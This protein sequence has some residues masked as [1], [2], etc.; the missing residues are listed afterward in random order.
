MDKA[1]YRLIDANANRAREALRVVED[2]CRLVLNDIRLSEKAKTLR[3]MFCGVINQLDQTLLISARN[4]RD[5]VGT[6]ITLDSEQQRHDFKDVVMAAFKRMSEALRVI[7]ESLKCVAPELAG[8]IEKCRYLSY[9]LEKLTL[10][11]LYRFHILADHKLYVLV[12]ESFSQG[13]LIETTEATLQ[14]GAD[15][16]QLREKGW[17]D[18]QLS[19]TATQIRAHCKKH[20]ALFIMNDRAD[21]ATIAKADGVH[22]GQDDLSVQ[23]VRQIIPSSSII[24]KSAHTTKEVEGVIA[25]GVD[26][27][28]VGAIYA[29]EVKP[30]VVPVGVAFIRKVRDMTDLPIVAI[31]GITEYNA[32]QVMAAGASAVAI[33][34]GIIASDDPEGVTR[35]IRDAIDS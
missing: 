3:H 11:K 4:I 1:N 28:A 15:I 22:V 32:A 17:P 6:L 34:Q 14:G 12:T 25:E 5:D 23:E 31:G 7:E 26:Y 16:V 29:T 33:C 18:N 2:C 24:G 10:S 8:P 13:D 35:R 20:H 30:D 19:L 9:D 21:I 27:I